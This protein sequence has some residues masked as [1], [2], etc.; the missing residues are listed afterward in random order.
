VPRVTALRA[1]RTRRAVRVELDGEPWRVLPLEPVVRA[2]LAVG[3]ELDRTRARTLGR[4]LRRAG[5]L[6]AATRALARRDR[7]EASLAAH[8]AARGVA[9]SHRRE[10]VA[11]L[12]RAGHVDDARFAGARARGLADRGYGDAAIA[13]DL[14]R[15]G[16]GAD[17]VAGALAALEPEQR[18]AAAI[19]DRDGRSP[20][21]ARRLAARG[22]DAETVEAVLGF[23]D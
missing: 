9:P 4:E 19:V 14:D 20:R 3:V 5:A 17:V 11:A 22:F 10:T 8:L 13:F 15:E 23:D 1:E 7:S 18:R 21:V 12:E 16:V 6:R 2:G